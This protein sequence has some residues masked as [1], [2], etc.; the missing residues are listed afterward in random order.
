MT[1]KCTA[2]TAVV[3]FLVRLGGRAAEQNASAAIS[4]AV[5]FGCFNDKQRGQNLLPAG[6]VKSRSK[7]QNSEIKSA[8]KP[9]EIWPACRCQTPSAG[10]TAFQL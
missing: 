3:G 4:V 9:E 5:P 6:T 7:L 1:V 8:I 2:A 10:L